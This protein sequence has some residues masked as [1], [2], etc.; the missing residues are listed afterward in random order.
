MK[1]ENDIN[2][3]I[4]DAKRESLDVISE[5]LNSRLKMENKDVIFSVEKIISD[6]RKNGD[7]AVCEYTE[8]FDKVVLNPEKIKV[9]EREINDAVK[10]V[11]KNLLSVLET[12]KENI[13][14]FHRAQ[15]APDV[16]VDKGDESKI[17]L[18]S[19]P[20]EIVGVYV[21]GG[22]AP[23]PSSVLMNVIPAKAAGVKKVVMCTPPSKD[24]SVNPMILAAAKIA[25]VDEI[26]RIGGAQ[27]IA[28]MA[29]GTSTVPPVDKICG[30]GNIYVNTAKRLVFG[31]TD[32]DMFA[33][34][35]EI[36]IIADKTA[37]FRFIAADMMAQAEHDILASAVLVTDDWNLAKMVAEEIIKTVPL[38][39]RAQ[40]LEKSLNDYC[41]IAVVPDLKT[42]VEFSNDFAPEHLE[43]CT[44]V[45]EQLLPQITNAGAV[46]LGSY[47]PESLGD[48][49]CGAN[50]V[51]PT[52]G[53]SRFFS[54][55][56]VNDF[57]KK[58][59]VIN[60]SEKSL[61][62]C[63]KEVAEFARSEELECHARSALVRFEDT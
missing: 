50:H 19:R 52:S 53:T 34:P 38:M 6:V 58:I 44:A 47:S 28:A 5:V 22:T 13:L 40:I 49:Y 63:F 48:Y 33:G 43:I 27:A 7:A 24:G 55:L 54:P 23:L 37:N 62:K 56:N 2:I 3:R 25:G 16:T 51:L 8:N 35:S 14:L 12:A 17:S 20:L 31:K 15:L 32:I 61:R 39:P 26:Y 41:A 60:Y 9:S 42:A 36:L 10:S 29:F 46:F 18:I 21:P 11:D 30:P 1:K 57:I 45:P 59:S 4:I